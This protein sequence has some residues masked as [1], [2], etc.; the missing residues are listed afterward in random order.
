MVELKVTKT[1]M[2]AE[3]ERDFR[4]ASRLLDAKQF[5][6]A[7]PLLERAAKRGDQSSQVMLGYCHDSGFGLVRS[8]DKALFW[9]RQ[10]AATG[11]PAA[12]ANTAT[13]FL[14]EGRKAL[15]LR[16][17]RRAVALG[18]PDALLE[19]RGI[20]AM[21][22]GRGSLDG[23]DLRGALGAYLPGAPRGCPEGSGRGRSRLRPRREALEWL[24]RVGWMRTSFSQFLAHER[25]LETADPGAPRD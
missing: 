11:D 22:T 8:R 20:R 10:A 17:F 9:Y 2:S 15:A 14:D 24:T 21:E 13:V 16:W 7:I 12:A 18:L 19:L 6:V 1:K 25:A 23:D 4:E 5:R 3:I